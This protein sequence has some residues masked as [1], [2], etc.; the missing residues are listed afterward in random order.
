MTR[1]LVR[2]RAW[3]FTVAA[4]AVSAQSLG[5]PPPVLPAAATAQLSQS[6]ADARPHASSVWRDT[7]PINADGTVTGYIE[8][9][10]GDRRKWEFRIARNA[11]EID[12]VMPESLGGYPVNYG[13]VPQ[14]I[15]YDGD[16]FDALVLGPPLPGGEVVRGAIVGLMHME[17]EKGLDSKVV[18]SSLGRDDRPVYELTDRDRSEIADYFRRYKRH[19]P[20]KFSRVPGWGSVAD[21]RA[22]V[23][24]THA[25]FQE[26]RRLASQPCRASQ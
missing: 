19:E 14:T 10:R 22:Y 23:T 5:P 24:T 12:R 16:P 13:F 25:F 21:G 26:C 20:G 4:T 9:A 6:L 18:L 8:I 17:D 3:K 7:P 2:C 11:L 1:S 15:S